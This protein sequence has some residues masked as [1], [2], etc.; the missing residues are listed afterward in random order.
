MSSKYKYTL[1]KGDII[2]VSI[3]EEGNKKSLYLI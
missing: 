2:T 1:T 3:R